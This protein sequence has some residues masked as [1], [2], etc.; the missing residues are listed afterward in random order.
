[1]ISV[2]IN[3]DRPRVFLAALATLVAMCACT[4]ESNYAQLAKKELASG[5]RYDSLLL[6]FYFGTP[7]K[8]FYSKCWQLNQ[9]GIIKEGFT[10]VTV[11]YPL[12]GLAHKAFF[13]FFPIFSHEKIQSLQG[14][15]MYNGWAPWNK[16][17]WSNHLIEDAR[18]YYEKTYGGNQFVP[19][20]SLGIGKAYVKIDGNRRLVLYYE[21]DN[22]V[23]VLFSDLT[24]EDGLLDL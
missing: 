15:L 9:Q 18:Q 12:E 24:N 16:K 22:R 20:E 13:D 5:I 7:E 4:T 23:N 10:N 1:M 14:Y 2:E 19:L 21:E 3:F 6:G 11:Y 8:E 17:L